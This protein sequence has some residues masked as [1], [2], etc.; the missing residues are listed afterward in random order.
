[1]TNIDNSPIQFGDNVRVLD[2][3]ETQAAG[4]AGLIGSIYGETTP[5]VTNVEVIG[6]LVN[7]FALN[8]QPE[9]GD[10]FWIVLDLVELID[11]GADTEIVI[12]NHKTV[13]QADGTWKEVASNS[14]KPWWKI[15]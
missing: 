12:G 11:H 1:M 7:D 5:S 13:R 9:D 15:W 4:V 3:P 14:K 6:E 8:V 2:T 10:G